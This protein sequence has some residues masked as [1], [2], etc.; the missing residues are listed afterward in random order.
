[1]GR[2]SFRV[3]G[4]IQVPT[5][6]FGR[7]TWKDLLRIGLPVLLAAGFIYQQPSPS[8]TQLPVLAAAIGIGTL[9]YFFTPYQQNLDQ[10]LY[11]G[12]RFLA[13][14]KTGER[15]QVEEQSS[16]YVLLENGTAVGCIEVG[17]ANLEMKTEAEQN[18]LHSIYRELFET[19]SYPVYI[20]SRQQPFELA[21]YIRHV[22]NQGSTE[23]RVCQEYLQYCKQL[24][25]SNLSQTRHI[26]VLR[27]EQDNL[28]WLEH[29]LPD[30]FPTISETGS[31]NGVEAAANELDSRCKDVIEVLDSSEVSADRITGQR[32]QKLSERWDLTAN[33]Q[34]TAKWTTQPKEDST[35]KYRRTLYIPELP[36]NLELG[37]T[38]DLLQ[39]AGLV[40][41]TQV[42][43]PRS[44]AE[45]SKKL[46][47]L[48][49]KLSAE[50][51]SLLRQGYRG[52]NK[53]E[54]LLDDVEWF[55]D[56]L[57]DREDQPVN[58]SVYIT[59]KHQDRKQCIQAFE[60]V[61]NRLD[62]L[63]I[64]YRQPVLRTDQALTTGNPLYGDL[65]T[66][67][68]LMPA[69]SAAAGFPFATQDTDTTQG[70]IYGVDKSDETPVLLDR[71]TWSSHSMARMGMVGSGK[72]Y[73][74]KIELLRARHVYDDLKI[75]V[76][77]PKQEYQ[78]LV[79]S[80]DGNVQNL[81]KGT[82]YR[83]ESDVVG[84]TV[85]DRGKRENVEL[86]TE[87]VEQIYKK[88]SQNQRKT[89]VVI[90]EARILLND[91]D[92]RRI[93]NQFVLEGRDTNTAVTLITQNASHF[94]HSREGREILDNMPGKV[95][96]RHDRVP[97]SVV[98]YF[99]LSQR[100][101]Q[102]L[103]ELKT[104]TDSS[105]SEALLRVSGKINTRLQIRST[106]QEQAV[107]EAGENGGSS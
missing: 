77:D 9:W 14:K 1:M 11:H 92:G 103:F 53:L 67:S 4:D 49:E 86:L 83:L 68:L 23:N 58:Y 63:Q 13:W 44:S 51:D 31:E 19:V 61:C 76:V 70:V 33:Q 82:A 60:Q 56:L 98:N 20:Y 105:Y 42:V 22:E 21:D 91:G 79:R 43:E 65:L 34:H 66:E 47:R 99:E 97:D 87:A 55:L 46:Q 6:F 93:L 81:D 15:K 35:G 37:W 38:V 29:Q 85:E 104:G 52:T 36:S 2:A 45:T 88:V 48:S 41:V 84:F 96:M 101:K 64:D 106:P 59:V 24:A 40:D 16:D 62:T 74:A 71:F 100:E 54:G 39:T 10:L 80:L 12:I 7:F 90:D 50:I 28:S 107:I 18:A 30:L 27:V 57:A 73:A 75:I 26:I 69:G 102:E 8:L 5:R 95:F 94:T 72:S 89:L 3:P 17:P 25:D 78:H 32:L